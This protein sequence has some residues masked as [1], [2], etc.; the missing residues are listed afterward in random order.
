MTIEKHDQRQQRHRAGA[1]LRHY[2]Q[3][4]MGADGNSITQHRLA[5]AA[6]VSERTIQRLEAGE[7]VSNEYVLLVLGGLRRLGLADQKIRILE[8]VLN[9]LRTTYSSLDEGQRWKVREWLRKHLLAVVRPLPAFILDEYWFIRATNVYILALHNIEPQMLSM[10][11]LWHLAAMK[12]HPR[13]GLKESRGRR[14][15]EYYLA[16]VKAF[17]QASSLY[18]GTQRYEKLIA[19]LE[20][21]EGF[22]TFWEKADRTFTSEYELS[23]LITESIPVMCDAQEFHFTELGG[24]V[25]VLPHLPPY[26]RMVW[27]PFDPA[28]ERELQEILQDMGL[29][30]HAKRLGYDVAKR[31]IVYIEEYVSEDVLREIGGWIE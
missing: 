28:G 18:G 1:L 9:P 16:T 5:Q 10:S 2:R 11:E 15:R 6:G 21:L 24:Y 4:L 13:L 14:W 22:A 26:W 27:V 29:T 19:W 30:E 12:F 25:P 8:R 31:P 23:T 20:N 7:R 17:Q 3:N